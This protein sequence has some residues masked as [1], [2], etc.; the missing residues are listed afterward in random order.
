MYD[1]VIPA[2]DKTIVALD[3]ARRGATTAEMEQKLDEL[4]REYSLVFLGD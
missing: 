2:L 1:K 3:E 4:V